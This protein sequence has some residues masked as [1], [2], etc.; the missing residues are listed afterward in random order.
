MILEG[1]ARIYELSLSQGFPDLA[2]RERK[3][4]SPE[5]GHSVQGVSVCV[6]VFVWGVTG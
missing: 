2:D 6:C 3:E 4:K 5:P 1:R